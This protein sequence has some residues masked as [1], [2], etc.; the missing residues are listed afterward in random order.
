MKKI[1][2][3][4]EVPDHP[5]NQAREYYF[6]GMELLAYRDPGGPWMIQ[7]QRCCQCGEC[8]F[9]FLPPFPFPALDDEKG[10]CSKLEKEV[11]DNPRY[12]CDAKMDKPFICCITPMKRR[13]SIPTCTV[14]F[15]AE[16]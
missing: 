11:G 3:E 5:D 6:R 2:I 12:L 10:T 7:Q 4:I 9:G 14:E 1:K 15:E 13:E 16:E 8:C